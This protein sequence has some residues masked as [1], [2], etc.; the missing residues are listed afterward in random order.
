MDLNIE[1]WYSMK[2]IREYLGVSRDT[3]FAWI[4]KRERP[5]TKIGRL[6]KFKISDVDAWMKSGVAADK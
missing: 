5:A 1:R 6:W 2:E 4:E 3:I